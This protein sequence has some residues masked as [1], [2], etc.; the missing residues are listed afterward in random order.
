MNYSPTLCFASFNSK[1]GNFSK[2]EEKKCNY[3]SLCCDKHLS[4]W[5][6]KSVMTI[7]PLLQHKRLNIEEE[8]CHDKIFPIATEHGKNVT[9]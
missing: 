3:S 7:F 9:S 8:L 2:K 4:K 1:R 5:V 6:R